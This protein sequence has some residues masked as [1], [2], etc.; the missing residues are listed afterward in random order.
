M[1]HAAKVLFLVST[2]ILFSGC[3]RP[4]SAAEHNAVKDFVNEPKE[5]ARDVKERM[6]A[7]QSSQSA[8]AEKLFQD[9][10]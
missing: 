8:Q 7:A 3:E 5:Q 10:E 1:I 6:E 9:E 2:V 4:K